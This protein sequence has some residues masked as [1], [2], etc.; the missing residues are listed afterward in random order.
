MAETKKKSFLDRMLARFQGNDEKGISKHNKKWAVNAFQQ[1][2]NALE[3]QKLQA[4]SN[5]EAA[6]E[7]LEEAICPTFKITD[8]TDY[9]QAVVNAKNRVSECK[10]RVEEINESIE[11]F[12]SEKDSF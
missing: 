2:I 5:L 6:E 4:E 10:Q 3:G 7:Q 8:S 1:Q 9:L 12:Q 11:F